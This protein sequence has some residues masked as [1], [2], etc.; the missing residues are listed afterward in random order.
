MN[1]NDG[2]FWVS[3]Y[4]GP[5]LV[6]HR[7]HAG[8]LLGSFNSGVLGSQGLALDPVDGT[9]WMSGNGYTLYQFS[10]S[11]TPLQIVPYAVTGGGW[12]GMEFDLE[13]VPEPA[14]LTLLGAGLA[15]L[16]WRRR[17]SSDIP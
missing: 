17:P 9:L 7:S 13:P 5:D 1:P 4:G 14:S 11:G 3:Q 6:E 10:Q 8:A 2:S 16:L 12:Y 15:C